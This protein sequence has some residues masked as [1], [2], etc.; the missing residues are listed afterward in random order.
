MRSQEMA[1]QAANHHIVQ[2][3]VALQDSGADTELIDQAEELQS[4]I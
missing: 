4:E 3:I 1:R 2:T